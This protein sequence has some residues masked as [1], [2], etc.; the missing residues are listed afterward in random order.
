MEV[1]EEERPEKGRG[2]SVSF[3]GDVEMGQEDETTTAA[4]TSCLSSSSTHFIPR[5]VLRDLPFH[6]SRNRLQVR[7][8][9]QGSFK[10][11]MLLKHD[12][13]HILIRL[14]TSRSL[15]F[16]LAV[17]TGLLVAF[18]G[19]YVWVDHRKPD[20][21]CG[22]SPPGDPMNFGRAFAFSLETATTGTSV[23]ACDNM[24]SLSVPHIHVLLSMSSWLQLA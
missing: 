23:D 6:Q 24:S 11:F 21:S 16:L 8:N 13:F 1:V 18:A 3:A 22:L 20:L 2:R 9:K 15:P 4:T 19:I 5:L 10:L 14:P 12:W 17:W 7:H